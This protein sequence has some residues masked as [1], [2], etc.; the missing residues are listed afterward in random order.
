M[1]A[2]SHNPSASSADISN[3]DFAGVVVCIPAF[4]E[5]AG[6]AKVVLTAK[7]YSAQTIVCDDGSNDMTGEI[8]HALGAI[9]IRHQTNMGKGEALKSLFEE[10]R[11]LN[12]KVVVTVDADGQ[13]DATE[14][15]ALVRPILE[16]RADLVI[17]ARPMDS[18][19]MPR[20]R[21]LGNKILDSMVSR[22]TGR[23]AKDSQSG[24]RA[25][26]LR[27][28]DA[29]QSRSRGMSVEAQTL[30][31]ASEAGLRMET[32][33]IS[34]TYENIRRKRS[35]TSQFAEVFDYIVTESVSRSPVKYLG[36]PG[37]VSL[38]LGVVVGL[39][40][41]QT[42]TRTQQLALGTALISAIL[43]VVGT[44]AIA[45]SIIIKLLTSRE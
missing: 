43:I 22:R 2:Q 20:T 14:I 6:I 16:G 11:S 35:I 36:I 13:H 7:R 10:A 1:T 34:T 24:F 19:V 40:V 4:N 42:F 3:G 26:S 5:E 45:T 37:L 29:V 12:P 27:A 44:V 32:V 30:I 28:L 39:G 38:A 41:V 9:V 25:Y 33:P 18:E 15:S 21:I 31:D 23:K 8:A 17:G